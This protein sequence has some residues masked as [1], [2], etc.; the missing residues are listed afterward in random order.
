MPREIPNTSVQYDILSGKHDAVLDAISQAVAQ[1]RQV[2]A[3]HELTSIKIGDN[4]RFSARIRPRYLSGLTA[5]VTKV[6]GASVT[7]DIDNN[8]AYGRFQGSR[9]VRVPAA[10]V[11]STGTVGGS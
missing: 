11:E 5:K 3:R 6:N 4:V 8:P 9:N 7:V 10:L 2:L 1:R